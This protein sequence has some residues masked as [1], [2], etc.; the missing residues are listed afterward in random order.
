MQIHNAHGI[1]ASGRVNQL[2]S[3]MASLVDHFPWNCPM[4]S[5]AFWF[6]SVQEGNALNAI[7]DLV[8]QFGVNCTEGDTVPRVFALARYF[9]ILGDQ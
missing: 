6:T 4:E 2:R 5:H 8:N 9:Q 3:V 7:Y 1:S